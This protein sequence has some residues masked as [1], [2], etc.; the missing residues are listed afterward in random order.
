M[1]ARN[2]RIAQGT[3]R[4]V[5]ILGMGG[6]TISCGQPGNPPGAAGAI[7]PLENISPGIDNIDWSETQSIAT[8]RELYRD[9]NIEECPLD[10]L[11]GLFRNLIQG[12]VRDRMP[13]GLPGLRF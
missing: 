9:R 11:P 4:G 3:F 10:K 12:L 6:V 5:A 1:A 7:I 8:W 2:L 13:Q